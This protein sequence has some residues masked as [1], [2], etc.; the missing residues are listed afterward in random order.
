[1]S[2][3]SV[4]IALGSI[5]VAATAGVAGIGILGT[6]A[7][8]VT[9]RLFAP[10]I[11]ILLSGSLLFVIGVWLADSSGGVGAV[12]VKTA[13]SWAMISAAVP[14]LQFLRHSGSIHG[15]EPWAPGPD[16]YDVVA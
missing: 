3:F 14:I 11:P 12:A 8:A 7:A 6:D 1:M 5:L 4:F 16:G 15:I 9:D 10:A 2:T 13:L